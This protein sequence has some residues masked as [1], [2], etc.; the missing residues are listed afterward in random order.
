MVLGK[1][2][3]CAIHQELLEQQES[4]EGIGTAKKDE[5]LENL[6]LRYDVFIDAVKEDGFNPGIFDAAIPTA[7]QV[8]RAETE[9]EQVEELIKAGIFS[10]AG[11]C[12]KYESRIGYAGVTLKGTEAATQGE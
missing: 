5:G 9:E 11:Q 6:Q 12:S 1:S 4:E 8:N 2:W 10:A 7:A 3:L